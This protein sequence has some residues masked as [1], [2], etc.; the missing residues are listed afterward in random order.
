MGA[1]RRYLGFKKAMYE[2]KIPLGYPWTGI[3]GEYP[4]PKRIASLNKISV[5]SKEEDAISAN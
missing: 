3:P 4:L 5:C 1:S 2:N